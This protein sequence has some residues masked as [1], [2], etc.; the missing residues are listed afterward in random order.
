MRHINKLTI[1][2]LFL[3]VGSQAQQ[4]RS[5]FGSSS[6]ASPAMSM[7]TVDSGKK[8]SLA[9]GYRVF[10]LPGG[11]QVPTLHGKML[12]SSGLSFGLGFG[13]DDGFDS[14]SLGVDGQWV[15][16]RRGASKVYFEGTGGLD[17]SVDDQGASATRFFLGAGFGFAHQVSEALELSAGYGLQSMFGTGVNN[18]LGTTRNGVTGNFGIHWHL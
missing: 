2:A 11:E 5:T 7:S 10:A 17:K 1:I 12:L 9:F 8:S 14:L 4:R 18:H 16:L 13:F 3:A 15:W 6:G